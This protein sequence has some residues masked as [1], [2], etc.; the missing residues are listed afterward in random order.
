[1][2]SWGGNPRDVEATAEIG[3]TLVELEP[4]G[5]ILPVRTQYNPNEVDPGFGLNPLFYRGHL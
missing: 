1:M 3:V 4:K 2:D 5:D